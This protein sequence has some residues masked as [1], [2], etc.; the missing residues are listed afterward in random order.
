MAEHPII[1][2]PAARAPWVERS[3]IEA[4]TTRG[5]ARASLSLAGAGP[6]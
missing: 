5:G 4:G 2:A 3:T 6:R 1:P